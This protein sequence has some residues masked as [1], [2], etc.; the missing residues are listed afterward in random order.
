MDHCK[1]PVCK[2][3]RKH[4]PDLLPEVTK[5]IYDPNVYSPKLAEAYV[6][7]QKYCP[8]FYSPTEALKKGTLF[9]EL[10]RP[11]VKEKHRRKC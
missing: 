7:W 10:Y 11:Y 2:P 4:R 5:P 3:P 1:P 6:L 8:P 9:P